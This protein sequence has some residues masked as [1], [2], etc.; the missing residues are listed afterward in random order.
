MVLDQI[1]KLVV[2]LDIPKVEHNLKYNLKYI[3]INISR[4]VSFEVGDRVDDLPYK[5]LSTQAGYD[6]GCTAVVAV[7]RDRRL[8]VANA[9]D[10][11]CVVSRSGVAMAM[12]EDHKPEDQGEKARIQAAGGS[13]SKDGRVNSSLNL[14]RAL[15]LS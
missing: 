4:I 13:V 1:I 11:R 10:S 14:S 12:S 5:I 2:I 3:K 15:G 8:Y 9:G 6:S 7:L